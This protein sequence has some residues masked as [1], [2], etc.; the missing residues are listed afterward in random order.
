M[1]LLAALI[2]QGADRYGDPLPD[3]A[4]ARLGTVRFRHEPEIIAM[5]F[6]NDGTA[7]QT[8]GYDRTV[9]SWDVKTGEGREVLK[10]EEELNGPTCAAWSADL[11]LLAVGWH[12]GPV[13]LYDLKNGTRVFR[14]EG[15]ESTISA[16]AVTEDGRFVVSVDWDG[17]TKVRDSAEGT[18]LHEVDGGG[19][20]AFAT[21]GSRVVSGADEVIC[22]D[23]ATGEQF[24]SFPAGGQVHDL[25][26]APDGSRVVFY[27]GDADTVIL[28]DGMTGR[29]V[30]GTD[31]AVNGGVCFSGKGDWYAHVSQDVVYIRAAEDGRL[32]KEI[33]FDRHWAGDHV[34]ASSPDGAVLA[35]ATES[36]LA[37]LDVQ[38]GK[39][40]AGIEG[41]PGSIRSV[42]YSVD[43][44]TILTGAR[45][46][47]TLRV[48]EAKT[49]ELR[50][51]FK[52]SGETIVVGTSTDRKVFV[53][54]GA[55][56]HV[57]FVRVFVWD[58][59]TPDHRREVRCR[60][61]MDPDRFAVSPDG[62]AVLLGGRERDRDERNLFAFS[63]ADGSSLFEP[64]FVAG[65]IR[66]IAY[67]PSGRYF[68]VGIDAGKDAKPGAIWDA[69]RAERVG[70]FGEP[71]HG[72]IFGL[73]V[74]PETIG[75]AYGNGDIQLWETASQRKLQSVGALGEPQPDWTGTPIAFAA[76]GRLLLWVEAGR[77]LRCWDVA[78]EKE[79]EALRVPATTFDVAPDG[80]H[81]V[82]A[83]GTSALV[84]EL[85]EPEPLPAADL[86]AALAGD[87][88]AVA[89]RTSWHLAALGDEVIENLLK[90][91]VPPPADDPE[92]VDRLIR[93]IDSEDVA[94]R[95]AAA[96]ALRKLGDGAARQL[97]EALTGTAS[98]EAKE[99]IRRL[100][101]L[102]NTPVASSEHAVR[103]RRVMGVL[104]R[105]GSE[106][107]RAALR[108]CG[109]P[110]AEDALR[111]AQE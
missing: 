90:I 66:S 42:R 83:K 77:T 62:S 102:L 30:A 56:H 43:G 59:S 82:V 89:F 47:D 85:P 53:S 100:I 60:G 8:V 107:A 11:S 111:R 18:L 94:E 93:R 22:L 69:T 5:R 34:M 58:P 3:G 4:V 41:H 31:P 21:T 49:G 32:M 84:Y 39:P 29:R 25:N 105:I 51:A 71:G 2:L 57:S 97:G 88:A 35:V 15:S 40:I 75:A 64:K 101:E 50:N 52:T 76:D 13:H 37:I 63:V 6:S 45:Y 72:P 92:A 27:G 68:A 81:V 79:I 106:K 9:R 96:E 86:V 99:R 44:G 54:E 10:L 55:S 70:E 103:Q 36:E 80:M 109:W 23:A 98:P 110:G 67:L 14:A 108:A 26:A 38:S 12:D 33:P 20:S 87:D 19:W 104:A 46:D 48:W 74:T 61:S 24:W 95:D 65:G 7:V 17:K 28:L 16:V 73:A 78:L 1:L 91:G